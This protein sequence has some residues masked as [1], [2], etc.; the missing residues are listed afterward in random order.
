MKKDLYTKLVSIYIFI[1]AVGF[2]IYA[3]NIKT[4]VE[5]RN[6]PVF[7]Q[8]NKLNQDLYKISQYIEQKISDKTFSSATIQNNNIIYYEASTHYQ[9][10]FDKIF[11][12][13]YVEGSSKITIQYSFLIETEIKKFY[14]FIAIMFT[15]FYV[16]ICKLYI[17]NK[18]LDIEKERTSLA[19]FNLSQKLAHDI[20]SPISTLNLISSKIEDPDIKSLQLAVVEQINAIAN[21]LLSE[22]R[23]HAGSESAK[24]SNT[25]A[26]PSAL[27]EKPKIQTQAVA[28]LFQN[29]EK[30]Y[31][32]K[33]MAISQAV[34]FVI[35]Y[36]DIATIQITTDVGTLIYR[37]INNFVQNAIEATPADG[38]ITI[39][40]I[41][42]KSKKYF[43]EISVTDTGKGIPTSIL[44]RLGSEKLSY[45]KTIN[46][47]NNFN[48]GSGIA[49]YNAKNDLQ[50]FGG[51]LVITSTEN[52]GTQILL[53]V[54]I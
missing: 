15:I 6:Q 26:E 36:A 1:L 5:S 28:K 41:K 37:S 54:K 50:K 42:S 38:K 29:L 51:D 10:F 32:F 45:G 3:E 33:K 16:V 35:Q 23:S 44:E 48:S 22:N 49:L 21:G 2:I 4:L 19:T 53:L 27:I 13:N 25:N 9:R 7:F 40:C 12:I 24:Q 31:A 20:R 34:I 39:S 30:E 47:E 8:I 52:V 18:N 14:L 46:T 11:I 43:L 17:K